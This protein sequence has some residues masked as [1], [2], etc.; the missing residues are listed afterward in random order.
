M[1]I[2]ATYDTCSGRSSNLQTLEDVTLDQAIRLVDSLDG[3]VHTEVL[4]EIN[5]STL[6][7]SGGGGQY[8]V[9][10]FTS[11]EESYILSADSASTDS[12]KL[13]VGGQ[14]A[15]L[16]RCQ[17]VSRVH[18]VDAIRCFFENSIDFSK[19]WTIDS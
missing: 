17:V 19:G 7:V 5:D 15:L 13:T 1:K 2:S 4:F 11:D 10:A 3:L 14:P 8:F 18:A 12:I 6:T 9:S 16:P